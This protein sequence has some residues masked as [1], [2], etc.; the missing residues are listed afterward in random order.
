MNYL[1]KISYGLYVIHNFA[2][3]ICTSLIL[4]FG[5]PDW[6]VRLYNIPVVRILAFAGVTV[7]LAAYSWHRFE[8]PINNLKRKFPYPVAAATPSP[9][10]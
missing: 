4:R 7:G 8:K 1:G 5:S 2:V 3:S 6:L 10:P 9:G